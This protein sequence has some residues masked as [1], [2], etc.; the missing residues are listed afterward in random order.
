MLRRQFIQSMFV[1]LPGLGTVRRPAP[2]TSFQAGQVT[3]HFNGQPVAMS[4][5]TF[6][7]GFAT[8][9]VLLVTAS[10][11][12]DAGVKV[13]AQALSTELGAISAQVDYDRQQPLV[14]NW[15]AMEPTQ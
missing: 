3:L 11:E 14:V 5:V 8:A 4:A 6:S 9:P 1:T 7:P 12:S 13:A 2:A 10:N 15:I